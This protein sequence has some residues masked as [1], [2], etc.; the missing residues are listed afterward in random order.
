MRY[1]TVV[2]AGAPYLYIG[3]LNLPAGRTRDLAQRLREALAWPRVRDPLLQAG[4]LTVGLMLV[5][6]PLAAY[7]A[8]YF[9]G[10]FNSGYQS[11]NQLEVSSDGD[12]LT[13]ETHEP[14]VSMWDGYINLDEQERE[15]LSQ[16]V[17]FVAAF[18]PS[19]LC[20]LPGAW[21]L[22]RQPAAGVALGWWLG[23]ISAI[24][25]TQGWV[26][27]NTFT[28]IRY[29][30]PLAPPAGILAAAGLARFATANELGKW[31]ALAATALI[32]ASGTIAF[33]DAEAEL[34]QRWTGGQQQQQPATE[35]TIFQL[36]TGPEQFLNRRVHVGIAEV[37]ELRGT[38]AALLCDPVERNSTVVLIFGQ[39]SVAL[40]PGERISLFA[41]FRADQHPENDYALFLQSANDLEHLQGPNGEQPLAQQ[42][43]PSEPSLG[44]PRGKLPLNEAQ[45]MALTLGLAAAVLTNGGAAWIAWRRWS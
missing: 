40:E 20:A 42:H 27:G 39:H 5:G 10:P 14:S 24:Y 31:L 25:L 43:Q 8:H 16:V 15:N 6:I 33:L 13:V 35:A 21:V 4:T 38:G 30:L 34:Q 28:D 1:T 3:W 29:Y 32:V 26:L 45:R 19:L 41:Q 12:N 7:N 2:M 36:D 23:S 11:R 22:R 18:F 44:Q 37:V 9:G 17:K